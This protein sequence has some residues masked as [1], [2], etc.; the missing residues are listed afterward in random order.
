MASAI[1]PPQAT[2]GAGDGATPHRAGDE[3]RITFAGISAEE[4][5]RFEAVLDRIWQNLQ[6]V[7]VEVEEFAA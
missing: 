2:R 1:G 7:A 5:A 6:T 4:R 3:E